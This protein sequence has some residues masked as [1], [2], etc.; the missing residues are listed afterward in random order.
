MPNSKLT[1]EARV[2]NIT[3]GFTVQS[4]ASLDVRVG[5]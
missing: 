4:G 2:V 3:D 5:P 1:L